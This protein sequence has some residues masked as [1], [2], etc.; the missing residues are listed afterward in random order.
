MGDLN[1]QCLSLNKFY[2]RLPD[3]LTRRAE[4]RAGRR[5]KKSKIKYFQPRTKTIFK[6]RSSFKSQCHC[7]VFS[8]PL[9]VAGPTAS[10]QPIYSSHTLSQTTLTVSRLAPSST[11]M[12]RRPPLLLPAPSR[13]LLGGAWSQSGSCTA[14]RRARGWKPTLGAA[15]LQADRKL[16]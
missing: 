14:K 4:M 16:R 10:N 12:S 5:V 3:A 2:H 11:T 9:R 13:G 7:S 15:I 6:T 1:R 8:H